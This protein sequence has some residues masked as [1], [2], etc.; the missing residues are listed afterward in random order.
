MMKFYEWT[1]LLRLYWIN[2]ENEVCI[3][4]V[5]DVVNDDYHNTLINIE[6]AC[7]SEINDVDMVQNHVTVMPNPMTTSTTLSFYNP[8]RESMI[9]QIIDAQGKLVRVEQTSGNIHVVEKGSLSTGAYFFRLT[10]THSTPLTG[11]FDI[12]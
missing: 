1:P 7:V 9:L 2:V 6:D 11:R 4:A 10:G 12:K 8:S 5:E 3:S